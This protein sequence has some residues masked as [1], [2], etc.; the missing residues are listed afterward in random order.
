MTTSLASRQLLRREKRGIGRLEMPL[1]T[2]EAEALVH[3]AARLDVTVN[4][5]VRGRWP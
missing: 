1:P 3:R 4:T 2:D 5:L